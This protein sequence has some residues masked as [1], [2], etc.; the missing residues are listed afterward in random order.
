PLQNPSDDD[1]AAHH[2]HGGVGVEGRSAEHME[3]AAEAHSKIRPRL[4]QVQ[5]VF[6]SHPREADQLS[7][8]MNEFHPDTSPREQA[9]NVLDVRAHPVH[10]DAD[11]RAPPPVSLDGTAIVV[12]VGLATGPRA[13][14][15]A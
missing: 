14:L 1:L 12:E 10:D 13:F 3:G 2:R 9:Y 7:L 5:V 11:S 4:E 15:P 8:G 6:N